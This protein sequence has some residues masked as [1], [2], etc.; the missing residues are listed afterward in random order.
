MCGIYGYAGDVGP[1]HEALASALCCLN[2][3]RGAD[4]AGIAVTYGDLSERVVKRAVT[5]IQ[6]ARSK[7]FRA[8]LQTEHR[9]LIGHTR[10]ATVGEICDK[11]A[12]PFQHGPLTAVHNGHTE[13]V[14]ALA[15]VLDSQYPVDSQY[16]VH[17]L[18]Q[19]GHIDD[20]AGDHALAWFSRKADFDLRLL[21]RGRELHCATV[22]RGRGLVFSSQVDHLRI[23]LGIAGLRGTVCVVPD[24]TTLTVY[25]AP[26][27][28]RLERGE[29][30]PAPVKLARPKPRR[31]GWQLPDAGADKVYPL[32]DDDLLRDE[33]WLRWLGDK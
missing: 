31:L 22:C 27:K 4:S 19:R 14:D 3:S 33:D 21:R 16:L 15:K 23:A 26:E 13:N 10:W 30:N 17:A 24:C 7:S 8:A 18:D 2:Q 29:V 1:N 20:A 25:I 12:H 28:I 6:F 9:V 5:P 11:N 32:R